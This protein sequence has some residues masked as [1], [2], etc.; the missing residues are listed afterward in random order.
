M[1]YGTDEKNA[2]VTV[3]LHQGYIRVVKVHFSEDSLKEEELFSGDEMDCNVDIVTEEVC[4]YLLD[5]DSGLNSI[6]N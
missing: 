6:I 3:Q 2:F 5:E 4:I 1:V